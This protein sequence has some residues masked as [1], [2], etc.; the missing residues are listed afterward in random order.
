MKFIRHIMIAAALMVAMAYLPS[1]AQ[2]R[3][4]PKAYMFGFA[5]SFNVGVKEPH[6]CS[7]FIP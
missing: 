1:V 2:N 5:A 6:R 7:G 4:V 3:V